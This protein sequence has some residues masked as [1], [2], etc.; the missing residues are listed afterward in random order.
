VAAWFTGGRVFGYVGLQIA[1]SFYYAALGDFGPTTELAP[2]RDR[3]VGILIALLI[4]W[5]V[6][7]QMWPV[8]TVTAMR[9]SLALVLRDSASLFQLSIS[10]GSPDDRARKVV[11][12]RD[13]MGTTLAS[14]R[15]MNDEIAYDFGVDREAHGRSGAMILRAAFSSAAMGWNELAV[16]QYEGNDEFFIEPQIV[17]MRYE[18][19]K[20]LTQMADAVCQRLPDNV[21]DNLEGASQNWGTSGYEEYVHNA[22][23][24]FHDLRQSVEALRH[25]A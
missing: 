16:L 13:H 5:F 21:T 9:R 19:A 2:A 23:L 1:F 10:E 15:T 22:L 20:D 14:L 17:R 18:M 12:V 24:Q 6:F 11:L 8:R 4:M 7:D 3:L 25:L